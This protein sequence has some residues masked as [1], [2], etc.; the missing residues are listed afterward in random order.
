MGPA[1]AAAAAAVEFAGE[2]VLLY[3][4]YL[5]YLLSELYSIPPTFSTRMFIH[6]EYEKHEQTKRLWQEGVHTNRSSGRSLCN[7]RE[8]QNVQNNYRRFVFP[9]FVG[10]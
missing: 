8:Y 2:N 1:A 9:D 6:M 3:F 4:L 7:K 10:T 5:A